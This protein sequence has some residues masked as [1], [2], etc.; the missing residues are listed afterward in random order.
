MAR[1]TLESGA[2]SHR[3]L[4]GTVSSEGTPG[5]GCPGSRP[6]ASHR[7]RDQSLLS[8]RLRC[9]ILW[10]SCPSPTTK[11]CVCVCVGN[12]EARAQITCSF[13]SLVSGSHIG[14]ERKQLLLQV[15]AYGL[16]HFIR[17]KHFI[18]NR[19]IFKAIRQLKHFINKALHY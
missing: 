18:L 1:R 15:P 5:G 11:L 6:A 12:R 16:K 2:R 10:F 19:F 3:G 9:C 7:R 4:D 17:L 8:S 13:S 14:L